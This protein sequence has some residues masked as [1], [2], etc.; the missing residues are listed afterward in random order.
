MIFIY[1]FHLFILYIIF[2][3]GNDHVLLVQTGLQLM[4]S[5]EHGVLVFKF[6][7]NCLKELKS[8]V[9]MQEI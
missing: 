7:D 6:H 1:I 8:S 4:F 3:W 9:T 2:Y 5:S